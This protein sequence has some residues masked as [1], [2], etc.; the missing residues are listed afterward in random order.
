MTNSAT[1]TMY[2][3]YFNYLSIQE[4]LYL[5]SIAFSYEKNVLYDRIK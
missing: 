4:Q 1:M 3:N 2:T 5:S